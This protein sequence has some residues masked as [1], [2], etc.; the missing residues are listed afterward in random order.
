MG[1]AGLPWIA[2]S[3][4]GI[5]F[6]L[7][8]A[9]LVPPAAAQE[10]SKELPVIEAVDF[11]GNASYS[12][13]EL[14]R[15]MGLEFPTL[16][17][18]LRPR[19]RFRRNTFNRELRLLVDYYRR[20]GFGGA[21]ARLDSILADTQRRRVRL[22]VG[23]REGP[24][25]RIR[26]L[27]FLPQQVF[28]LEEL[29]KIVPFKVG[30]PFPFNDA[31]RGRG[32]RALRLAFLTRGYLSVAVRDSTLL[33]ADSTAA[34]L[35]YD[36]R[37]G[38]RFTVRAVSISGNVH[39][40]PYVIRRELRI[41][42]GEVYSYK[43][44]EDSKQNLY[45][46]GLFRG[47]V[48][49]EENPDSVASTVDLAVRLLER[50]PAFVESSVGFGRRDDFEVNVSVG[51]GHRNLWGRGHGIEARA[52]LAYN[53]QQGG[54]RFFNE[55]LL[56]Y[57]MRNIFGTRLHFAPVATFTIDQRQVE[58]DINKLQ[59]DAPLTY[60]LGR[61]TPISFGAS[62]AF[63][64]T[65]AS[66]TDITPDQ[67]QTRLIYTTITNNRT[68]DFFNPHRGSTRS[69]GVERAGFRGDNYFTRLSG[70]HTFYTPIRRMVLALSLRAGW[71]EAYGPS[72]QAS[73]AD[74]GIGGVPFD[75]LFQAGGSSTVRGF[76][77]YSLGKTIT[78][79]Q[80]LP[81]GTSVSI[82]T[83]NVQ[84]GTVLLIG[85]IELRYPA[86]Y[87]SRWGLNGAVFVDMGNVWEDMGAFLDGR[88][89][90]RYDHHY[91]GVA[92][93][94]WSYGIG[95]RYPTPFGPIR[96]D[97]GL[98]MKRFGRREFHFAVGYPF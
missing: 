84:A 31:E 91:A 38:K 27:R 41:Q 13:D 67:L 68:D 74:I 87:F 64:K 83:V 80:R 39:T 81:D 73:Q 18:P 43:L 48:I 88:F 44:I 47:V 97:M 17:H 42:P 98:P 76:D 12:K 86:L 2:V 25:S 52:T 10:F 16:A 95:L 63:T 22:R 56:R 65:T 3:K 69:L 19:P 82:D 32:M 61:F 15:A 75:Y 46:T 26:E 93:L 30:D 33:S 37:P 85:N 14:E 5:V 36:M 53:L 7:L 6:G 78:V 45:S 70:V 59:L 54:D 24:R 50:N 92:D 77:N 8:L 35:V 66:A 79:R 58:V 9:V 49:A 62:M 11:T 90:P 28:S 72:R 71:V 40:Q 21:D 23:V 94:R 60:Q 55:E 29:R 1:C 4:R 51:W 20:S 96:L 57:T 34:V 89:G